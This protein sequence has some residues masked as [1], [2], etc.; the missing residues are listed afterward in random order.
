[1][2][3]LNIN[4]KGLSLLFILVIT[5]LVS[6]GCALTQKVYYGELRKGYITDASDSTIVVILGKKNGISVGDELNVYK[7]TFISRGPKLPPILKRDY[8]GK[9]K[10]T[11]IIDDYHSKAVIID[12]KVENHYRVEF[13]GIS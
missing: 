6:S 13:P 4:K 5:I 12:G 7:T 8:E 2:Y 3:S 1:M 10:I 9:I 11:E